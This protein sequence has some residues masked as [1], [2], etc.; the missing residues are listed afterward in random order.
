M[1]FS[2]PW[3]VVPCV[4]CCRSTGVGIEAG[5]TRY[6]RP[7]SVAVRGVRWARRRWGIEVRGEPP[8]PLGEHEVKQH[9]L[10][11]SGLC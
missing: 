3:A 8:P 4:S 9:T 5:P 10:V 7:A 2:T 11:G 6:A 1:Y